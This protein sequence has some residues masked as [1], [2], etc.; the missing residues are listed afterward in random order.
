MN[1]NE[2]R[3]PAH[4]WAP[5]QHPSKTAEKQF[6][7]HLKGVNTSSAEPQ[8]VGEAAP[9]L[10]KSEQEYFEELYPTA[11]GEVHG[12][13]PYTSAGTTASVRLGSLVDRRG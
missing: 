12:Y 8:D 4:S 9:G 10:T 13:N 6:E 3:Q 7:K 11:R 2:I 1:V 5:I